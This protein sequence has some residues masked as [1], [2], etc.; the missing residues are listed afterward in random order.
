MQEEADQFPFSSV[1]EMDNNNNL[2]SSNVVQ[3]NS[4]VV[5]SNSTNQA[6]NLNNAAAHSDTYSKTGNYYYLNGLICLNFI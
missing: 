2:D 5:L 6:N 3:N 1:L 4:E